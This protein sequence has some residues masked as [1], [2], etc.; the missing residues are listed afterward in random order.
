MP[1]S[2][3]ATTTVILV[4]DPVVRSTNHGSASDVIWEP[5]VETISATSSATTGRLRRSGV[6]P[7]AV[8]APGTRRQ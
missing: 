4:A 8:S 6:R 1:M 2:S 7:S 5:V 3:A